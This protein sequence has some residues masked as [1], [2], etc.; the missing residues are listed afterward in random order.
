LPWGLQPEA[1][2]CRRTRGNSSDVGLALAADETREHYSVADRLMLR[3]EA[4]E[5]FAWP[6]RG[7]PR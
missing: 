2:K 5:W 3:F 1:L 7:L 4:E 6:G